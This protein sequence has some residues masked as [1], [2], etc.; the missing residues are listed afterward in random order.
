MC[1]R[2]WLLR[3]REYGKEKSGVDIWWDFSGRRG[4]PTRPSLLR[5]LYLQ[6]L[7]RRLRTRLQHH[8]LVGHPNQGRYHHRRV[9]NDQRLLKLLQLKV[10]RIV[11]LLMIQMTMLIM[12]LVLHILDA[13]LHFLV[14]ARQLFAFFCKV[15]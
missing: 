11:V 10:L 5:L 3:W 12:Y 2:S 13:P 7:L 1:H 8:P 4:V 14:V 9:L 15:G 6:R